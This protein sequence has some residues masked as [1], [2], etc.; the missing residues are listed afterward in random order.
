MEKIAG[1]RPSPIWLLVKLP[2]T[3]RRANLLVAGVSLPK[4][5][6]GILH[7]GQPRLEITG[8]AYPSVRM[9]EAYAGLFTALAQGWAR[10]R[11]HA[12]GGRGKNCR[13]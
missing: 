11:D 12:C 9:D 8:Q 3:I 7:V 1:R 5:R 4:A 6:G 2:W 10:R 13:G